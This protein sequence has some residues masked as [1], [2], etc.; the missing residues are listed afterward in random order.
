VGD[1][2]ARIELHIIP[3]LGHLRLVDLRPKHVRDLVDA[4]SRTKKRVRQADGTLAETDEVLA[5]RTVRHIYGTLRVMLN[6]AVAD[7]LI[8]ATPPLP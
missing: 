6:D 5:P 3:A 7:E 2:R 4:L 1:D 8:A